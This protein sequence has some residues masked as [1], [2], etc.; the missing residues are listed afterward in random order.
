MNPLAVFGAL[1]LLFSVGK[2]NEKASVN[3]QDRESILAQL[4]EAQTKLQE[5][6]AQKSTPEKLEE[7]RNERDALANKLA[8][9]ETG[10]RA[11]KRSKKVTQNSQTEKGEEK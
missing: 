10:D 1:L 9:F 8:A 5:L 4:S 6:E 11:R 2:L 7:I 3:S